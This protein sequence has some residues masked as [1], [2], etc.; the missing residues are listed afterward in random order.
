MP[1]QSGTNSFFFSSASR[2]S[3]T[4]PAGRAVQFIANLLANVWAY[5]AIAEGLDKSWMR[6]VGESPLP[7]PR[8]VWFQR[9][10]CSLIHSLVNRESLVKAGAQAPCRG[11]GIAVYSCG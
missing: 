5:T 9:W 8:M 11:H 3:L 10:V 7:H 6:S 1:E 4:M 2:N